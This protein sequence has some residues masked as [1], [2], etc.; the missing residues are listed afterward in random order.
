MWSSPDQGWWTVDV[1]LKGGDTKVQLVNA[2]HTPLSVTGTTLDAMSWGWTG[3]SAV[4]LC[5]DGAGHPQ[6]D[7]LTIPVGAIAST[8]GHAYGTGNLTNAYAAYAHSTHASD[9]NATAVPD[10]CVLDAIDFQITTVVTARTVT[11]YLA[12]DSAGSL[13]L[14][15]PV[16]LTLADI[17]LMAPGTYGASIP[18]SRAYRLRGGGTSGTLWVCTKLDA[19]TA[20][21]VSRLRF[22]TTL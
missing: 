21:L 4:R 8:A 7:V 15:T 16:T 19:G 5:V 17:A 1:T 3:A 22:R 9:A 13:P 6:V 20:V 2:A 11:L 14:S 12:E 18:L 10:A